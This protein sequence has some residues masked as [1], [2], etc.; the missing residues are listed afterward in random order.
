MRDVTIFFALTDDI[1]INDFLLSINNQSYDKSDIHLYADISKTGANGKEIFHKFLTHHRSEYKNVIV[2]DQQLPD[3]RKQSIGYCAA[4]LTDY[5]SIDE[6]II[7]H[8]KTLRRL[9][10]LNL[11]VVAPMLVYDGQYSNFHAY[12]D[13]R[14]YYRSGENYHK[15]LSRELNGVLNVPVVNSCYLVRNEWLKYVDYDDHSGRLEYVIFSDAL[16]KN[17][18]PQ[19]I[20]N[21]CNYGIMVNYKG[22][23]EKQIRDL[24]ATNN[25][26]FYLGINNRNKRGVIC[27]ADWLSRYVIGEHL[28]LMRIL[29]DDYNFHILNCSKLDVGKMGFVEDLNSYDALLIA[30]HVYNKIPLD[31]VTA[32]KIYK[33]DDMEN[34]PE[35]TKIVNF[36]I[37][38]SDIVVSPY[39][40]VFD[41]FYKHDN[42]VWVPYSCALESIRRLGKDRVQQSPQS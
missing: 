5:F 6:N 1:Y 7:I 38:H 42:V 19:Y 8:P 2:N 16:R 30:Y 22:K 23:T 33:I 9:H 14:G 4:N 10:D 40:Y 24:E 15:I 39:A 27:D 37:R 26:K 35:Y 18:I 34:D 28:Y 36:N 3:I 25:K 17:G 20:D 29:H 12:V 11:E 32:Y 21:T 31:R 41:K 13:D